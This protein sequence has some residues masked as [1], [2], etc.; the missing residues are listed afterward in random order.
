MGK[1]LTEMK[2]F[3]LLAL[4]LVAATCQVYQNHLNKVTKAYTEVRSGI[5]SRQEQSTI[6]ESA[7]RLEELVRKVRDIIPASLNELRALG[8]WANNCDDSIRKLEFLAKTIV[9]NAEKQRYNLI[10]EDK[11]PLFHAASK[12]NTTCSSLERTIETTVKSNQ[13]EPKCKEVIESIQKVVVDSLRDIKS[14][15]PEEERK[16]RIAIL[17]ACGK[18]KLMTCDG[19][20]RAPN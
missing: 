2:A 16:I 13:N 20:R 19:P 1:N 14:I 15:A 9:S 6:L 5:I 8:Y 18:V 7:K 12:V 11:T 3:G 10:V 17:N 4:L